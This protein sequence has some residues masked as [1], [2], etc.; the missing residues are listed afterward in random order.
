MT[1]IGE[2]DLDP[3]GNLHLLIVVYPFK[4]TDSLLGV[5]DGV[6]RLHRRQAGAGVFPGFPLGLRLLDVG[7]VPQHDIAQP[8]GGPGGINLPPVALFGQQG[9]MAAVVDVG[10][11]QQNGVNLPPAPTGRDWFS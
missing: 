4:Q 6:I 3:G 8:A 9:Q 5:L 11:G 7:R 1:H 10:M 2:T